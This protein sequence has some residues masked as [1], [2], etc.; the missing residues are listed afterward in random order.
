VHGYVGPARSGQSRTLTKASADLTGEVRMYAGATAPSGWLL[1]Q[2][3]AVS[4]TKY[5]NL[6]SIIGATYG[7]GDGTTTFNVPNME[8]NVPAGMK[9]DDVAFHEL[10]H[11]GGAA[12]VLLTSAESGVPAH[13]HANAY[14]GFLTYRPGAGSSAAVAGTDI[15]VAANTAASVAA[16][17][18]AA[19]NNLQPY[20][21]LNFIIRT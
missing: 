2:G 21:C 20:L 8:G 5:K 7:A 3:Q 1:C 17:A 16:D 15:Q 18:A 11:T 9:H 4:R 14:S 10:G 13:T 6:F 12:T 19:H